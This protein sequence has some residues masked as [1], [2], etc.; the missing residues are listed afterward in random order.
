[1]TGRVIFLA[2]VCVAFG[3]LLGKVIPWPGENHD[4]AP[5]PVANGEPLHLENAQVEAV[6]DLYEQI[7]GKH[8]IRDANLYG[9]PPITIKAE[10]LGREDLLKMIRR[11]LLLNGVA[12]IS[13]DDHTEKVL[14]T[15]TNKNP[16]SEGLPLYTNAADLPDSGRIVSYFMPLHSMKPQEAEGVFLLN[17]P[18]HIYGQYVP[19]PSADAIVL[20]EDVDVVRK[21]I[22]L[23]KTI[24]ASKDAPTKNGASLP[25][26]WAEVWLSATLIIAAMAGNF[27]AY[28]W[29]RRKSAASGR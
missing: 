26:T 12:M 7:S 13:M 4:A 27:F 28:L 9:I 6:L 10:G 2:V 15:G 24:D 29:V 8:L 5:I 11:T 18:P 17:S 1:M 19:A 22:E 20:T 25:F 3:F 14:T 21:L 23:E 16:R